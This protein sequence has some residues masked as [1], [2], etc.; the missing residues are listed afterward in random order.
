[1]SASI[2]SYRIAIPQVHRADTAAVF[3]IA[4]ARLQTQAINSNNI[5]ARPELA[6]AAAAGG[7]QRG[8]QRISQPWIL[9]LFRDVLG[10]SPNQLAIW[11]LD[12]SLIGRSFV[13]RAFAHA[14][15]NGDL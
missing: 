14:I 7:Y 11:E 12:A 2:L 13:L 8:G 6:L 1:M 15:E 3:R 10:L 9:P 4:A 5:D